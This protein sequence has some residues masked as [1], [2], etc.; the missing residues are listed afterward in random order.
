MTRLQTLI[1]IW[2]RLSGLRPK[3]IYLRGRPD[4]GKTLRFRIPI[5]GLLMILSLSSLL[6]YSIMLSSKAMT[7]HVSIGGLLWVRPGSAISKKRP[8][9][10]P[11]PSPLFPP[12]PDAFNPGTYTSNLRDL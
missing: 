5:L 7:S 1:G 11:P 6:T 4:L 2:N 10:V 8:W 12:S 9:V 3:T